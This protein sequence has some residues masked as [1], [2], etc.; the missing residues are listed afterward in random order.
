MKLTVTTFVTLD[1]IA[2]APGGPDE[3]RAG[4][5]EYGGWLAPYV[6]EDFGNAVDAWFRPADAFLF[7]RRTYE[8]FAAYWPDVT[9]ED[10]VVATKFNTLPKYVATRT[11]DRADWA[12]TELL[13]GDVAADVAGIKA[14]PGRELQVHGSIDLVR[15]LVRA[16]LVDE[17]RLLVFPVVLG[18]G[19]RLFDGAVP[20]ALRLADSR[21]TSAG[22][23]LQTYEADGRP[24]FGTVG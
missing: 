17:F 2:Q 21:T 4:G 12:G 9:G 22:V 19:K 6:D 24:E 20:T 3:D 10:D 15:T 14:R 11:L 16:D 1:G 7:G 13:R 18:T 8:I 5:F 23:M